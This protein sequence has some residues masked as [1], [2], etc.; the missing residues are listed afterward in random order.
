MSGKVM[1]G[2]TLTQSNIVAPNDAPSEGDTAADVFE[3]FDRCVSPD[4]VVT[5]MV[6]PVETVECF[7]RTWARLRGV[8][9]MSP[10]AV[11]ALRGSLS[12]NQ[13]LGVAADM[14]EAVRR[15]VER[16]PKRCTRCKAGCQEYCTS[17]PAKE[18]HR[19]RKRTRA[20]RGKQNGAMAR[21]PDSESEPLGKGPLEME[22]LLRKIRDSIAPPA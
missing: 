17:C 5:A 16:P 18:A 9:P 8:V 14:V 20:K 12:S 6:L 22:A 11:R 10:E 19:A 13:P 2:F 7:W 21:A 1:A 4:E 3:R 15:F